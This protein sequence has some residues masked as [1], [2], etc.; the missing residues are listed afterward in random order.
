MLNQN[1]R[2]LFVLPV[3]LGPLA[4][5]RRR[6]PVDLELGTVDLDSLAWTR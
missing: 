3:D 5:T 6:G 1:S 4:W 2:L